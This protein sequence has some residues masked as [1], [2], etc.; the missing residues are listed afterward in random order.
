MRRTEK[1]TATYITALFGV[2]AILTSFSMSGTN[3][4]TAAISSPKGEDSSFELVYHFPDQAGEQA[5]LDKTDDS[6]YSIFQLANHRFFDVFGHVVPESASCFSRLQF[7]SAKNSS[8]HKN[9]ILIKLR[10]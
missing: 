10:I 8:D 3:F 9:T 5:I 1:H 6:G 4:F 7:H 2:F